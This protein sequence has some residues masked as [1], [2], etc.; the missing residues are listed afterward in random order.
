MEFGKDNPALHLYL[1]EMFKSHVPIMQSTEGKAQL[2]FLGPVEPCRRNAPPL[3]SVIG[4]ARRG[5]VDTSLR[6]VLDSF[7]ED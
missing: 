1:K 5:G 7:K 6:V 2:Y 3:L 4:R